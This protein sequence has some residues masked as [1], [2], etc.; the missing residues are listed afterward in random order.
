MAIDRERVDEGLREDRLT[1]KLLDA[2]A[3]AE[4]FLAYIPNL[5]VVRSDR[6]L[7][8]LMPQ[9]RPVLDGGAQHRKCVTKY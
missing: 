5:R 4:I 2:A 8:A 9:S 1:T 6:R 3:R 7:R